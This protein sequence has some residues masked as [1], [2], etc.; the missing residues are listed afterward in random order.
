MPANKELFPDYC[1]RISKVKSYL[2][3]KA[4]PACI[5][6]SPAHIFYLT[7]LYEVEGYLVCLPDG[8]CRFFTGGI[9]FRE[10]SDKLPAILKD[11]ISIEL[12]SPKFF[13]YLKNFRNGAICSWDVSVERFEMLRKKS[14]IARVIPDFIMDMRAIKDAQE[15]KYIQRAQSIAKKT[16]IHIA[17]LVRPKVSELDLAAEI[18][19]QINRYGGEGESFKPV[20]ASGPNSA[21]P[22]H[23]PT[24]RK[25]CEGDAVVVD[26]GAIYKGYASDLTETFLVGKC[27]SEMQTAY[28]TLCKLHSYINTLIRPGLLCRELHN[29]AVMFLRKSGMADYFVHGLGHGVGIQVHEKPHIGSSSCDVLKKGMVITI[30]P[31]IYIPGKFGIRIEKM[32]FL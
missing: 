3:R 31:G 32:H 7:A 22:H 21:Y 27:S 23:K 5:I 25:I 10:C 13:E 19:F 26:I 15:K 6:T 11:K 2:R 28:R 8:N 30:E 4:I 1:A 17:Q 16:L 14:G 9:F 12:L 20:I 18:E 24:R 29:E